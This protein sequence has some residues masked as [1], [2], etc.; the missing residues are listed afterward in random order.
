MKPWKRLAFYLS[1]NFL[2]SACATLSVLFLWDQ[3]YGPMPRDLFRRALGQLRAPATASTPVSRTTGAQALPTPTEAYLVYQVKAGDTFESLAA[4]F[5]VSVEEL[6]AVNGFTRVQPLGE[7]EVL[8]IPLDPQGSVVIESV[9]GAGDLESERVLI[10]HRQGGE[11]YLVNWR[12][13]DGQGNVFIFPATPQLILFP[14][15][16][17]NIYTKAGVNNVVSLYWGLDHP[18]WASGMTATLKDAEGNVRAT[19]VIP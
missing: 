12:L 18:I 16:A 19:Y 10:K 2:V 7:G 5:G 3:V 4:Q 14:G 15:G 1:L 8:R 9:I 6:V 17:V 11:L 13:E